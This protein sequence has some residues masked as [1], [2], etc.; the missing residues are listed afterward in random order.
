MRKI[1]IKNQIV[2]LV[3]HNE[4]KIKIKPNSVIGNTKWEKNNKNKICI[5]NNKRKRAPNYKKN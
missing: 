1:I 2:L 5:N 4:N 3:T